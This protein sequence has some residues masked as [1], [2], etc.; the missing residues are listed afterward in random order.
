MVFGELR[1]IRGKSLPYY[2]CD[3]ARGERELAK[4]LRA[5]FVPKLVHR[6]PGHHLVGLRHLLN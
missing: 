2:T 1:N 6:L 3:T 5:E 4:A